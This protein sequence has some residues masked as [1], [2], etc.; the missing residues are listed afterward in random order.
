MTGTGEPAGGNA[1]VHSPNRSVLELPVVERGVAEH[2]PAGD[3]DDGEG[4]DGGDHAEPQP[5]NDSLAENWRA[6]EFPDAFLDAFNLSQDP[7]E[8]IWRLL[9]QMSNNTTW[10]P[11]KSNAGGQ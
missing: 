1:D 10:A 6:Y 8:Q 9:Q 11:C 7:K 5:G 3:G 4:V 2:Q